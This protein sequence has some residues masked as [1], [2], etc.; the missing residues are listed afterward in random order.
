ML[1]PAKSRHVPLTSIH[2]AI[3]VLPGGGLDKS[4]RHAEWAPDSSPG[5]LNGLSR[6]QA[7]QLLQFHAER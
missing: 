3:S 2:A 1:D 6:R 7:N 4:R 5:R